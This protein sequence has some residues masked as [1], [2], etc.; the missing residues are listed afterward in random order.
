VDLP[1]L[2]ILN[3]IFILLGVDTYDATLQMI[4]FSDLFTIE[5]VAPVGCSA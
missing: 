4:P 2:T 5:K 1:L 3:G